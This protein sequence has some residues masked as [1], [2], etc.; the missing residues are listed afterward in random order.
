MHRVHGKPHLTQSSSVKAVDTI[1]IALPEGASRPSTTVVCT[2]SSDGKVR[3]FDL[4]ALPVSSE[5]RTQLEPV[6]EYDTK[7]TRLTCV[8]LAEGDAET[9][10]PA[11]GK[12]KRED[13]EEE[14][15][16][17]PEWEPQHE[18]EGASQDEDGNDEDEE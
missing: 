7:G 2:I 10:T 8:A 9:P 4:A 1:R 11:A 5:A 13:D 16:Q 15:E 3:L 12:R 18:E 17:E 6:A 14:A